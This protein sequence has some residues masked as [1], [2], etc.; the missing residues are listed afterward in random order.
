MEAREG[1]KVEESL[2]QNNMSSTL[3]GLIELE[4]TYFL[5]VTGNV[6]LVDIIE[7]NQLFEWE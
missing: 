4:G 1:T 6:K 5:K 3:H 7:T 2:L